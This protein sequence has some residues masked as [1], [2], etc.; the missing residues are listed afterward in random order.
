MWPAPSWHALAAAL[1]S[2]PGAFTYAPRAGGLLGCSGVPRYPKAW[3]L[4]TPQLTS[5]TR[6]LAWLDGMQSVSPLGASP[7]RSHDTSWAAAPGGVVGWDGPRMRSAPADLQGATAPDRTIF[8]KATA[9]VAGLQ[10][11]GMELEPGVLLRSHVIGSGCLV[12]AQSIPPQVKTVLAK[13][14]KRLI[15]ASAGSEPEHRVTPR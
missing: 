14:S 12:G 15:A 9:G 13:S 6:S 8:T 1:S 3:R 7:L 5:S 10:M 4:S 2:S 11:V